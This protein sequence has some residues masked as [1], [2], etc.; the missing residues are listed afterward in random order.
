MTTLHYKKTF[1]CGLTSKILQIGKDNGSYL[2]FVSE[3]KLSFQQPYKS[4][5]KHLFSVIFR[6]FVFSCVWN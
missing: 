5:R 1:M 2:K 4:E 6:D 3:Q